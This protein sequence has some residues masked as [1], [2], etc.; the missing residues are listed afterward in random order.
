MGAA[1]ACEEGA[2][3]KASQS[4]GSEASPE[5]P[6]RSLR[7]GMLECAA[8]RGAEDAS[9]GDSADSRDSS[10][11]SIQELASEIAERSSSTSSKASP[12]RSGEA[13]AF[14][15][16]APGLLRGSS[17]SP[18]PPPPRSRRDDDDDESYGSD[19]ELERTFSAT[20][21]QVEREGGTLQYVPRPRSTAG[22][23]E[24]PFVVFRPLDP[25]PASPSA[26][27]H[28]RHEAAAVEAAAKVVQG[29]CRLA[30]DDDLGE[31]RVREPEDEDAYRA[32]LAG[33]TERAALRAAVVEAIDAHRGGTSPLLR[34]LR[35][36]LD[37]VYVFESNAD[38]AALERFEMAEAEASAAA[39]TEAEAAKVLAVGLDDALRRSDVAALRRLV[40]EATARG[41]RGVDARLLRAAKDKVA[42]ADGSQS[43]LGPLASPPSLVA[44]RQRA[45]TERTAAAADD[46]ELVLCV[47]AENLADH[48]DFDD[49]ASDDRD[50]AR[51]LLTI[52][53][54]ELAAVEALRDA[55][56]KRD[57]TVLAQALDA[58]YGLLPDFPL[59]AALSPR[60]RAGDRGGGD[61][62]GD[63]GARDNDD[64][65]LVATPLGTA[66]RDAQA[67]YDRLKA[68]SHRKPRAS[69]ASLVTD[70]LVVA[71]DALHGA[72]VLA[73]IALKDAVLY[74]LHHPKFA[75]L[76]AALVAAALAAALATALA[77]AL[78]AAAAALLAARPVLERLQ[79]QLRWD[80]RD[81]RRLL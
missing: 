32:L 21:L 5:G 74:G 10:A 75:A 57:A 16:V 69:L 73:S 14:L 42:A 52:L 54:G 23:G 7:A 12:L 34:V 40:A 2:P 61:R 46:L 70:N 65:G 58:A 41:V 77:T 38:L 71:H 53:R 29:L 1:A 64:D 78:G 8:R 51:R 49:D 20:D 19:P 37:E 67:L 60:H 44:A 36:V 11:K 79:R 55:M 30:D 31:T 59:R 35:G 28:A 13:G 4:F 66:L 56:D 6:S 81:R 80:E 68:A 76:V 63:R 18:P 50:D 62:G 9:G 17:G 25:A 15:P 43:P 22:G 72:A 39:T 47:G 45:D 24:S 3:R 27:R 48:Y 26:L 33:S